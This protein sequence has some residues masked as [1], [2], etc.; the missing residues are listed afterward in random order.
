MMWN[1]VCLDSSSLQPVMCIPMHSSLHTL[2]VTHTHGHHHMYIQ[3][4]GVDTHVHCK[5]KVLQFFN[6]TVIICTALHC[7]VCTRLFL[8]AV[9]GAFSRTVLSAYTETMSGYDPP[10][11]VHAKC[12]VTKEVID[13]E[14]FSPK[15]TYIQY[16]TLDIPHIR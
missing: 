6:F 16:H 1:L 12:Q 9:T 3:Y 10:G 2:P 15:H 5:C 8:K 4:M 11:G 14:Y 13:N 7:R